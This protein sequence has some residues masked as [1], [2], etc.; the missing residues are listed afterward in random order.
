MSKYGVNIW[1]V[2]SY[3]RTRITLY[4]DN[5]HAVVETVEGPCELPYLDN[6]HAVVETVEGPC[7]LTHPTQL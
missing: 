4:L 6:F 3:V 5:F 7:E 2:F 1:S